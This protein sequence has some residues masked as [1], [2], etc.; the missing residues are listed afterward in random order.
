MIRLLIAVLFLF[1]CIGVANAE[2]KNARAAA[3]YV[4]IMVRTSSQWARQASGSGLT[5]KL[6]QEFPRR[7]LIGYML[8]QSIGKSLWEAAG[9]EARSRF[10]K[11]FTLFLAMNAIERL[12]SDSAVVGRPIVR[13]NGTNFI[14]D[15]KIHSDGSTRAANY[16]L[17][18]SAD[19]LSSLSESAVS[20]LESEFRGEVAVGTY[21]SVAQ[22]IESTFKVYG[23][24]TRV[25]VIA[26]VRDRYSRYLREKSLGQVLDSN[27]FTEYEDVNGTCP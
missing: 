18:A 14:I 2:S 19:A 15:A 12:S 23:V 20:Q 3:L 11:K 16:R 24:K 1:S 10:Q 4:Q 7:M 25:D 9:D 22:Q 6:C 26:Y 21:P 27:Y 8:G 13:E 5:D 17:A